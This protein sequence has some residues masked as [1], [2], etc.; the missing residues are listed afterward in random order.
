[1]NSSFVEVVFNL[2]TQKRQMHA[3]AYIHNISGGGHHCNI[4]ETDIWYTL[5]DIILKCWL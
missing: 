1:M 3:Q 4:V 2:S 5:V